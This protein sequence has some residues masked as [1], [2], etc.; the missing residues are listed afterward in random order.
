MNQA[1]PETETPSSRGPEAGR[2]STTDLLLELGEQVTAERLTIGQLIDA[3]Q[4]RAFG[5]LLLV[6]ALP[7][8]IPF[9]YGV[10]QAVSLPLVFV[11]CQIILGRHT[12]WLP[13]YLK[14]KS[15]STSAFRNMT[16]RAAPYVR[17][18]EVLSRPRLVWLTRGRV[19]QLLGLFIL[20][21]S[22]SIAIPLP[23]T[24]TVPGFAVAVMALGFIERDGL[25]IIAGTIIGTAWIIILVSFAGGVWIL[26]EQFVEWLS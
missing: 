8:S 16:A 7:C 4:D 6:L 18:F 17:W 2:K 9:L 5:F 26:L 25:L 22:T 12:L 1:I 15:F 11:A 10:P 3:L 14:S 13:D 19:E 21:F 20:V 23:L 24:N